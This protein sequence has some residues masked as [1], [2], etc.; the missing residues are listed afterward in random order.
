MK[1]ASVVM[2]IFTIILFIA[3][4]ALSFMNISQA[5]GVVNGK[6]AGMPVVGKMYDESG[7]KT[8]KMVPALAV[9]GVALVALIVLTITGATAKKEA[10]TYVFR[11]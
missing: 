6:V 7:N 9:S 11:Q 2:V 10:F 8:I 5:M 4:I 1:A 3:V